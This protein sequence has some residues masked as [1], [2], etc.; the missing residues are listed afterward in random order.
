MNSGIYCIENL[1]NGKK[2]IGQS[3]NTKERMFKYHKNCVILNNAIKKYG[4]ENFKRYVILYCES[5]TDELARYEIAC[6]KIFHSHVSEGG[7]NIS[8]GGKAPMLGRKQ[9][10]KAKQKVSKANLGKHLSDETKQ[11]VS[12][13]RL[14]K[15]LSDETKQRMS[16]SKKGK[17]FT[18]DHRKKL[19]DA[20]KGK[21][22]SVETRKK[23]SVA[24]KYKPS[25]RKGKHLSVETKRKQSNAKKGK[26]PS[27]ETRKKMSDA[28]M[29][30]KYLSASS[31]FYGVTK[32]KNNTW[33]SGVRI[34]KTSKYIGTYKTEI[35]AAKAYDEYIVKNNLHNSLNFK[36][37]QK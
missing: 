24:N 34:N 9:S 17:K 1:I 13:A 37:K 14:G 6:I 26:H 12:K 29:G 11:K 36:D 10:K 15:H 20:K 31:L 16:V 7:Y 18:D 3:I 2:Y 4:K 22:L 33:R 5:D 27:I 30:K 8:W 25:W 21:H 23:I 28:K 19:S 35:E 32:A